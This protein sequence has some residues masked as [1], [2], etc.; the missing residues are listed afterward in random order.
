MNNLVLDIGNVICEWNP[1]RLIGQA[2]PGSSYQQAF[3]ATIGHPDWQALDRGTLSLEDAIHRA[4]Q[5]TDLN[6]GGIAQIYHG[7]PASLRPVAGIG[8]A[9]RL[10]RDAGLS[11]YVLSN[12][13]THSW[14]WLS[15]QYDFWSVFQG[16]VVSCEVK[17]LKPEPE[18]YRYLLKTWQLNATET[19]FIDDLPANIEAAKAE[20]M[21]GL[22]MKSPS[23][24][25]AVIR[26]LVGNRD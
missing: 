23:Q 17:L 7:A 21:Q 15:S 19:L 26:D 13:P 14:N 9:I 10:A 18:I 4:Q 16:I 6:A 20:G 1:R 3:D 25:T 2:L 8:D 5:R 24:S 22:V 12:M 11:L